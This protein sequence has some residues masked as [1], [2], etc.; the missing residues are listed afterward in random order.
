[1]GHKLV[2][3]VPPTPQWPVATGRDPVKLLLVDDAVF[4][5]DFLLAILAE[6]ETGIELTWCSDYATGLEALIAGPYDVCLLDY[7][8]G[9]R[10]GLDLLREAK[11]RGVRP[12]II[13]LTGH[14]SA[15]LDHEAMKAGAADYL[16]KGDFSAESLDRI[17]RYL[18][19][20]TKAQDARR[21]S[22]E[23]Y[24]LAMEGSND[25][26]WDWRVGE[27]QIHFSSRWKRVVGFEPGEL[28]DLLESWWERVHDDDR[29]R[30]TRDFEAHLG[31]SS[32]PHFENEH[33]LRH[34]DGTW[35][36]VLVRGKAV[37]DGTGQATRMAGSLTD[38]T[39]ARSRDALTGLSNRVL[40]LDRLEHSFHKAARD[41]TYRFALLFI[42][43]DRFKNINDSLGHDIGDELLVSIARR[44]EGCVRLV[45]TVARL[46]GDEFVVLLDESREP[47]GA[48]R[49]ASRII[50]ELARGFQIGARELF[51]GAS[52]GIA[53]SSAHYKTPGEMLRDA[54]T[55]MYRAKAEGRGRFVIF[56]DAMHARAVHVLSVE[57][58]LRRALESHE[59][60]VYYQPVICLGSQRPLGFEALVRWRHPERGLVAPGDFI[61][62]AEDSSLIVLLD[63]HVLRSAAAQLKIWRDEFK[64]DLSVAVNASRRH[65]SR[66]EYSSEVQQAIEVAGLPARALRLEVTESVTMDLP[67]VARAQ[68]KQLDALGVQ[69][70]VDDFGVG[71]SSLSMLH[72]YPFR[73]LKLDR[74]FVSGLDGVSS[75][76]EIVRAILAIAQ[77]LHLEVVA[78]G[79]E[80]LGQHDALIALGCTRGQGFR[81]GRPMPASEA[82][83]WLSSKL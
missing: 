22:E 76:T 23:R 12:P 49:V 20:R 56:D 59:L 37:R 77:A 18:L 35:R 5:R 57:S 19:E 38:V 70:Y 15:Q 14:G 79:V 65:F 32:T 66:S 31:N 55:A 39:M 11:A 81:Y 16:V 50:E 9:D 41:P 40:Y 27:K 64:L 67:E 61:P 60:E 10:S 45:D 36:H 26:L 69:L 8:L 34:K 74:S 42:D 82:S 29:P 30:L 68:L 6:V 78:E 17:V 54:D 46:G 2:F 51:T 72:T 58:G 62:V 63:L 83:K 75:S 1:M 52:I 53:L 13:M 44:L 4:A 43:L 28:P 33:R 7:Q 73:G 21:D 47:D 25:G 71:Y 24:A 80:T 48:I 3:R